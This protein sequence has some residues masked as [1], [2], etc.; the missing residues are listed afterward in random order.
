[1]WFLY[2]YVISL[3]LCSAIV[4][5]T[6][7]AIRARINR[8]YKQIVSK[9][10]KRTKMELIRAFIPYLIPFINIIL[11]FIMIINFEEIYLDVVKKYKEEIKLYKDE[12]EKSPI[13]VEK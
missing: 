13:I 12:D 4:M 8:E 5:I 7:L 11:T 9:I 6:M 2:F 3:V 10:K 1:M